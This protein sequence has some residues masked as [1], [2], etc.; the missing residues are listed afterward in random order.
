MSTYTLTASRH[1]EVERTK[2]VEAEDDF[3][4]TLSAIQVILDRGAADPEGPWVRGRIE[5]R[6]PD[7]T[8]LHEMEEKVDA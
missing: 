6:S 1:G 2:T 3:D 8:L 4:A 5:L 7:G